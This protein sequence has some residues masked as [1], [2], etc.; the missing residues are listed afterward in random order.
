MN[1]YLVRFRFLDE[2][3]EIR[4]GAASSGSA[5]KFVES[6]YQGSNGISVVGDK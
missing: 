3:Y 6:T 4:I 1:E 2:I 5:I